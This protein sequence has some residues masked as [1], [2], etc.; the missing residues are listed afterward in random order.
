MTT[1]T[2]ASRLLRLFSAA[3]LLSIAA[4]QAWA[5]DLDQRVEF[6]IPPGKL[7][8]ALIHFSKQAHVQVLTSGER[9]ADVTT[10]GVSGTYTLRGAL[11]QLLE[12]SGLEFKVMSDDAIAV[13]AIGLQT[14]SQRSI[15]EGSET[16]RLA[17]MDDTNPRGAASAAV[18]ETISLEEIIVTAQKRQ[19]RL[20]DVPVA[21][22]AIKAE[23][24]VN[25]NLLR[26]E[27]YYARLPGVSLT[28]NGNGSDPMI[29]IRGL[30]TAAGGNPTAGVLIDE[31]PYGRSSSLSFPVSM[32]DIDP[33]DLSRLEV[34]RGPQ[35]TLYGASS[36]GGL[37][38]FV[39]ADPSTDALR[40]RVQVGSTYVRFGDDLGYSMRGSVNVPLAD[41]MAV[42]LSGFTAQDPGYI[43]NPNSGERDVNSRDSE[44]G[45]VS[46][47]W[48]P[49]ENFSLKLNAMFQDSLREGGGDSDI[50]LPELQRNELAGIGG[51]QRKTQFYSATM[52][53]LLGP[54]EI[55]S[56]SGYSV[57]ET[58]SSVESIGLR[59]L[60]NSFFPGSGRASIVTWM[61]NEKFSQEL[62]ASLPIGDHLTWLFGLY[63]TKERD[64][65]RVNVLANTP[66]GDVR[67]LLVRN[68]A[69]SGTSFE[70]RAA[71]TNLTVTLAPRF[72]VQFGGRFS[73][74]DQ[75]FDRASVTAGANP[76]DAAPN[77]FQSS[78]SSDNAF[79]YQVTPR[80]KISPD[81]MTYARVAS[82][83]RPGGPNF[84]C[85][86]LPADLCEFD[87]DTSTNYELGIKG[88]MLDSRLSFDA[89]VYFID[90][91]DLQVGPV[92]F[93]AG[94]TY[95]TNASKA[96]SKGVELSLEA[97][98]M[99]GLSMSAWVAY[100]DA[101]LAE[102]APVP[103]GTG[104]TF[105]DAGTDLPFSAKWTCGLSIDQRFP[106]GSE[107]SMVVG[108][109]GSYVGERPGT[110]SNTNMANAKPS[111]VQINLRTGFTYETLQ[112]NAFVNNVTDKR[113]VLRG[114]DDGLGPNL[115]NYI[116]PRTIGLS[117]SKDF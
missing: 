100:N 68:L 30:A 87:A 108:A 1:R 60:A 99:D 79:T 58:N 78:S 24:L 93:T 19:E 101:E 14:T 31:V 38:K 22:S 107:A 17:R 97:R 37:I 74:N 3:S 82:G 63:Y 104:S 5:V 7:S 113:G 75:V 56:A 2:H 83:Y 26:L 86:I 94:T 109:D 36:I 90:W 39:T 50:T 116:Q 88:T 27:D 12:S 70:E 40:G 11:S 34:L 96:E 92:T 66:S 72:D 76:L 105:I 32:P 43:D 10:R 62:R 110:L 33:G 9:A 81:L 16:L 20:L 115:I 21:V 65:Y 111:Y 106:V 71:F 91:D 95:L 84:N 41:T 48:R 85:G 6:N 114:G 49:S 59:G 45:R 57:D 102:R 112:L 67:G 51:T 54:L 4:P 47:L 69:L 64:E 28:L 52:T 89:A 77:F 80:F 23:T 98:P 103:F 55:V 29:I 15:S 117:M 42:R 61:E 25:S 35:G 46:A 44:G 18:A 73:E 13:S 8:G 53:G